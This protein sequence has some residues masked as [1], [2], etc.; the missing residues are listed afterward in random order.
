MFWWSTGPQVVVRQKSGSQVVAWQSNSVRRCS[1]GAEGLKWRSGGAT[2]SGGGPEEVRASSGDP[3]EKRRQAVVRWRT[4]DSYTTPDFQP[5][6]YIN[7]D[8]SHSTIKHIL[9]GSQ[10]DTRQQRSK[11]RA[12]V[13]SGT[14]GGIE[15]AP[16][17]SGNDYLS[18][19]HCHNDLG[20][21][22]RNRC[23]LSM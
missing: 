13:V 16:R 2:V 12:A 18:C 15:L 11:S 6:E 1:G 14:R 7:S 20:N 17:I 10:T 9:S 8:S 21:D 4:P 5:N 3:A 23:H 22:C 19:N